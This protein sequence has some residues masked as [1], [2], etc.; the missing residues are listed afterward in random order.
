MIKHPFVH[1]QQ[2]T[3]QR[4]THT[5]YTKNNQTQKQNIS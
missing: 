3:A 2:I 4:F 1:I 5:L